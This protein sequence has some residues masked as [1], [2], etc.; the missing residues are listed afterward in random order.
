MYKTASVVPA[1]SVM[2]YSSLIGAAACVS[3]ALV[4]MQVLEL[5]DEVPILD[6]PKN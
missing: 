3:K 1:H 2:C 4:R 5:L 6:F